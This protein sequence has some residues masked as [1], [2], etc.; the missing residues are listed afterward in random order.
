MGSSPLYIL[1]YVDDIIITGPSASLVTRFIKLLSNKFSSKD[2]GFLSYFLGVEV[3]RHPHG[4]LL[5]Q[6]KYISD[7]IHKANM[8]DCK[9]ITTPIT[10]SETLTLHGA[11]THPSPT[12]YRS[13]VGALQYLSLTRP[14]IAFTVNKLSQFMHAPTHQHWTALK[15]L[16]RYLQGTLSKGLLLRKNSPLHLPSRQTS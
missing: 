11:P 1:V 3:L 7:I 15:R 12:E 6:K 8:R 5:S 14:D 9:P 4:L 2:L 13:I 16:L 10:C